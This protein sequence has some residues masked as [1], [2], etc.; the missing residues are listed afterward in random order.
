MPSSRNKKYTIPHVVLSGRNTGSLS[1]AALELRDTAKDRRHIFVWISSA[2]PSD[3]VSQRPGHATGQRPP[4]GRSARHMAVFRCDRGSNVP[5]G[6]PGAVWLLCIKRKGNER[7]KPPGAS[8]CGRISGSPE[9]CLKLESLQAGA[10]FTQRFPSPRW[11]AT[12]M[13]SFNQ[14]IG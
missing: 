8:C 4:S 10:G 9:T 2:T 7:W 3:F 11:M 1:R 5:K 6:F 12:T 14:W 13:V